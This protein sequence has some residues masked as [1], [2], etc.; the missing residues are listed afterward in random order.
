VADILVRRRLPRTEREQQLLDVAEDVFIERGLRAASMQEIAVRA[1]VTKP[2]LYDHFGS[3]DGLAA[4]C[5][6]RAG[7][8]L[9][10]ETAAAV[11]GARG[12]RETLE[13]GIT[14]FF[15][16]IERHGQVWL[17]LIGESSLVGAAA[18]EVEGI[19]R[20][21]AA[22]VAARIASDYPAAPRRDVEAFAEAII[23]ACER[24]ALWR[25]GH[26]QVSASDAAGTVV[27]L[28][29]NGLASLAAQSG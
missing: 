18:E 1:G 5:I 27:A 28:L 26:P 3:K 24:V 25:R 13:A 20:D 15:R 21:Q 17:M 10:G 2:I 11:Q 14:A 9:L 8:V 12:P 7:V 29:W 6:R 23:G 22:Y 19:R 16:F 4:A